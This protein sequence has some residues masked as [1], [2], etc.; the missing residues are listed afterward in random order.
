MT[1]GLDKPLFVLPFDRASA[2]NSKDLRRAK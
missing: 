2:P 1:L